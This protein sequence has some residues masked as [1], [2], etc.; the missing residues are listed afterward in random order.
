MISETDM[1]YGLN[2]YNV[3]NTRDTTYLINHNKQFMTIVYPDSGNRPSNPIYEI[4]S[5]YGC[6]FTCMRYQLNDDSL[7]L[8]NKSFNNTG[9]AFALKPLELRWIPP[10][11]T[12]PIPQKQSNSYASR[13]VNTEFISYKI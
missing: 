11:L 13:T 4:C 6:Q 1:F 2:Y 9:Y 5:N 7:Q 10:I 3:E 8:Y 12:K